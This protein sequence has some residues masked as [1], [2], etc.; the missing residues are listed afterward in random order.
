MNVASYRRPKGFDALYAG[1]EAETAP[2][3]LDGR[4]HRCAGP[5]E[6]IGPL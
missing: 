2:R 1:L 5:G 3:P 4:G 6:E